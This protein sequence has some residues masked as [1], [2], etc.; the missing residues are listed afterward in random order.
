VVLR[1]LLFPTRDDRKQNIAHVKRLPKQ[2]GLRG[3]T[4]GKTTRRLPPQETGQPHL[5]AVFAE[6]GIGPATLH[7][8]EMAGQNVTL[9][10]LEQIVDRSNC[11]ICDVFG[12]K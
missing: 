7:R 9:K 3:S 12:Q 8:L 1:L 5:S 2:H 10:T 4:A 6:D 11:S